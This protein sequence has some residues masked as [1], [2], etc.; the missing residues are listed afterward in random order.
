MAVDSFYELR[1]LLARGV[2]GRTIVIAGSLQRA[3]DQLYSVFIIELVQF[4]AVP[5]GIER[6]G[7][8]LAASEEDTRVARV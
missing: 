2:A 1:N 3:F 5:L 7:S 6:R 8:R 4:A